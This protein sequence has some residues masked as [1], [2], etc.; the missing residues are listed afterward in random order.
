[1]VKKLLTSFMAL[2]LITGCV[3]KTYSPLPSVMPTTQ[4]ATQPT[5]QPQF[6]VKVD[7]KVQTMMNSIIL[8]YTMEGAGT[9]IVV[10]KGKD[11][12][13]VLTAK[14]VLMSEGGPQQLIAIEKKYNNSVETGREGYECKVLCSSNEKDLALIEVKSSLPN[15]TSVTFE[16]EQLPELGSNISVVGFPLASPAFLSKG[17]IG[18]Y[19]FSKNTFYIETTA[20]LCPG[21]S[22]GPIFGSN[23]KVIG[24]VCAVYYQKDQVR[25]DEDGKGSGMYI[26]KYHSMTTGLTS[27]EIIAWL[28]SQNYGHIINK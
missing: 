27:H 19:W 15:S 7:P 14:H 25:K 18:K 23:G 12:S 3:T 9:G 2:A 1:M 10:H 22:G 26:S 13:Y 24:N 6:N 8:I 5:T 28:E 4:P 16:K 21:N 11:V 20:P 17:Y